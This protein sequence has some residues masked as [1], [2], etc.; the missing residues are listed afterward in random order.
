MPPIH[1]QKVKQTQ[2]TRI[3]ISVDIKK[4]I[5]LNVQK[6]TTINKIW[7]NKEK[8]LSVLSTSQSSR[9][10]YQRSVQFPEVDKAMQIWTS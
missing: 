5:Y 1:S 3:A 4:K 7:K 9:I 8:W 6:I 10:F 2:Q